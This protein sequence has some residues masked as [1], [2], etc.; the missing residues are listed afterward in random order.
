MEKQVKDYID[1]LVERQL[2]EKLEGLIPHTCSTCRHFIF[3]KP[4][5]NVS[6]PQRARNWVC[7]YPGKVR[8][9]GMKFLCWEFD[10]DKFRKK[11]TQKHTMKGTP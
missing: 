9:A 6:N 8:V 4:I 5:K 10:P 3:R 2:K 11:V 7:R 1:Q